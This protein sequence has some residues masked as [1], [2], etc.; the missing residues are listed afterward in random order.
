MIKKILKNK[1]GA[2]ENVHAVILSIIILSIFIFFIDLII[3]VRTY[4][5]MSNF[6]ESMTRTISIQGSIFN[7]TPTN[8]PGGAPMYFTK[9]DIEEKLL[10]ASEKYNLDTRISMFAQCMRT[11]RYD[12]IR[13]AHSNTFAPQNGT[14]AVNS[15]SIDY[16]HPIRTGINYTYVT[17]AGNEVPVR[18]F[19]NALSEY[20]HSS[21]PWEY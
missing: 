18:I 19:K 1:K 21:N 3:F 6:L 16:G 2:I 9:T 8:F 14:L 13:N 20:K 12:Y 4:I 17:I 5:G 11:G 7:T 10:A 15:V